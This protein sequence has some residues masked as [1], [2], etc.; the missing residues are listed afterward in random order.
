M[1]KWANGRMGEWAMREWA[2][3]RMAEGARYFQAMSA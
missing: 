2:N 3:V 1:G